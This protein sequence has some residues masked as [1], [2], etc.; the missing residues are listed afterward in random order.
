ME[1]EVALLVAALPLLANVWKTLPTA[2]DGLKSVLIY[3]AFCSSN[4]PAICRP[5]RRAFLAQ[6]RALPRSPRSVKGTNEGDIG[7][8]GSSAH[9]VRAPGRV[10]EL[11]VRM[12]GVPA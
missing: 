10:R 6:N 5:R 1:R 8:S 11:C 9:G 3:G 4:M 12:R 7:L 2:L